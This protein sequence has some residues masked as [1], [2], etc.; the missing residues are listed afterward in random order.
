MELNLTEYTK[1]KVKV[2]PR[3]IEAVLIDVKQVLAEDIYG[4]KA[5]DPQKIYL[6]LTFEN[7][8]VMDKVHY[9][10]LPFY[11]ISE[12]DNRSK[13]GKYIT[14]YGDLAIGSKATLL[15]ANTGFYEVMLEWTPFTL[16]FL[17][18]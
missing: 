5:F 11:D 8:E 14:K 7:K 16:V 18:H 4:A 17:S 12:L 6:R 15:L 10:D 9:E 2:A 13:L 1:D 3:V